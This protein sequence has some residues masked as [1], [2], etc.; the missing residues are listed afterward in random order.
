MWKV[1]YRPLLYPVTLLLGCAVDFTVY[2][3]LK[4]I[5]G[6]KRMSTVDGFSRVK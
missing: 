1:I 3:C 2:F 5:H 6:L 4:Y